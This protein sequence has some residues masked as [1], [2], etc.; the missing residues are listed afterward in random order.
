M[1]ALKTGQFV[2]Y[3]RTGTVGKILSLS[4]MNGHTFAELDTTGLLYRTD[5]LVL[6]HE[7]AKTALR[8][9]DAKLD[10]AEEQAKIQEMQESAWQNTDQSCEGGG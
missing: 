5:Q 9:R 10:A 8:A 6:V 7:E 1:T 2:R 3:S 4:E